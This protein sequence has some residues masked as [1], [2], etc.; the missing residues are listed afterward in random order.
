MRVTREMHEWLSGDGGKSEVKVI[1]DID[2]HIAI[3]NERM[4]K[5]MTCFRNTV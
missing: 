3:L 4:E 5:K 2:R 1:N